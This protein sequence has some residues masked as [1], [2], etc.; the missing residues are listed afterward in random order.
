MVP[1]YIR[2]NK[3]SPEF[4]QRQPVVSL[5]NHTKIRGVLLLI[6]LNSDW[7]HCVTIAESEKRLTSK[8]PRVV[9]WSLSKD[10]PSITSPVAGRWAGFRRSIPYLYRNEVPGLQVDSML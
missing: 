9:R 10:S 4:T 1:V 5:K 2:I 7:L 8:L 3:A 6:N